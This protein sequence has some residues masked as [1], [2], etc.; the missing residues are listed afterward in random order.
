MKTTIIHR[1]DSN[2]FEQN[3]ERYLC[4]SP[5]PSIDLNVKKLTSPNKSF[6]KKNL[7]QNMS[8]GNLVS[9][10]SSIDI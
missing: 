5:R 4:F 6:L 7:P 8:T 2:Q 3:D 9:K 1:K 10:Y